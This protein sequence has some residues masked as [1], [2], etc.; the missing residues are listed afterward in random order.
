MEIKPFPFR[1]RR[2]GLDENKSQDSACG[3]Q[4]PADARKEAPIPQ[5][6]KECGDQQN[7]SDHAGQRMQQHHSGIEDVGLRE[8]VEVRRGDYQKRE[9]PGQGPANKPFG[10]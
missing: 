2:A 7:R 1:A 9:Q 8:G 5:Q 6:A 10:S 4:Q 3:H